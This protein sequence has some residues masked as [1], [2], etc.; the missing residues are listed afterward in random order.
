MSQ[1]QKP[2][3]GPHLLT[4]TWSPLA[5]TLFLPQAHQ[6][7]VSLILFNKAPSLSCLLLD[8]EENPPGLVHQQ[9]LAGI[10]DL[11]SCETFGR[12]LSKLKGKQASH[13]CVAMPALLLASRRLLVLLESTGVCVLRSYA[14]ITVLRSHPAHALGSNPH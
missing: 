10:G 1:L 5:S 13:T 8:K 2:R 7:S 12:L 6:D 9:D 11:S 14:P 3:R 4:S